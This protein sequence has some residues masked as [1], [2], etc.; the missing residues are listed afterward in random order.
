LIGTEILDPFMGM[1]EAE[2]KAAQ[3]DRARAEGRCIVCRREPARPGMV[4]CQGCV[5]ASG[6]RVKALRARRKKAAAK[7]ASLA[8]P[9]TK[10][11]RTKK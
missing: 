9:A 11:S 1:T 2:K 5:D 10:G 8:K 6:E 4:T 3:R 7:K